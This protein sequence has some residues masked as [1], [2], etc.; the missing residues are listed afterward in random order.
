[1]YQHTVLYW[2]LYTGEKK[3]GKLNTL[4]VV[5][6]PYTQSVTVSVPTTV[7]DR[8]PVVPP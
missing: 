7:Y 6:V 2:Y 1:M 8:L 5:P 4:T 3:S